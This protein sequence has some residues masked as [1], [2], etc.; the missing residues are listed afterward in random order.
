MSTDSHII[1]HQT[2]QTSDFER[3]RVVR[4]EGVWGVNEGTEQVHHGK[5]SCAAESEGRGRMGV[6]FA[7]HHTD[8]GAE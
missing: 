7:I 8:K 2:D 6:G 3:T 4:F 1:R 5:L